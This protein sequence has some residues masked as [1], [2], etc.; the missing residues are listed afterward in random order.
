M[1]GSSTTG[2]NGGS[3]VRKNN[4]TPSIPTNK[5][6]KKFSYEPVSGRKNVYNVSD[7]RSFID[8]TVDF[9][10]GGMTIGYIGSQSKK[11]KQNRMDYAGQAAGITPE[12]SVRGPSNNN[13]G[14][15][16]E[17]PKQ[18]SIEQ[19]KVASQTNA[20]KPDIIPKGPTTVEINQTEDDVLK[21]KRKGRKSTILT[22]ITG[23]TTP[24]T[25]SK[26]TLLG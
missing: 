18:K 11:Q 15:N 1:G 20:L 13:Q 2:N 6:N 3:N 9:A 7:N 24:A 8:K 10:K 12:G 21:N 17:P 19:P 16:D 26:K 5:K 25:L 23:V 14:G 22:S 4:L